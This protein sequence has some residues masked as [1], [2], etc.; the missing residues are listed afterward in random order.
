MLGQPG[1]FQ[2]TVRAMTQDAF[3]RPTSSFCKLLT[4]PTLP[5][6][7]ST[8]CTLSNFLG[9]ATLWWGPGHS[10]NWQGGQSGGTAVC[11]VLIGKQAAALSGP[12]VWALERGNQAGSAIAYSQLLVILRGHLVARGGRAG[13]ASGTC[14]P[15]T[16][17]ARETRSFQVCTRRSTP[18]PPPCFH[19][20]LHGPA[21]MWQV[22]KWVLVPF[23]LCSKPCQ[24][25]RTCA[26][27]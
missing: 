18:P 5:D 27:P 14:F 1:P 11:T 13:R 25:P 6:I 7:R 15:Q 9:L 22:D 4:A 8:R 21:G 2:E 12:R 19:I 24:I 23:P 3:S 20:C 17:H 16:G 10:G 26:P